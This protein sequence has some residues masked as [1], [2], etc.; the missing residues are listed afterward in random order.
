MSPENKKKMYD[1]SPSIS[2]NHHCVANSKNILMHDFLALN[3][4]HIE[5]T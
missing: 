1:F 3:Q 4:E 2:C 5:F